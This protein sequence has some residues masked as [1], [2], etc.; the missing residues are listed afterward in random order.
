MAQMV[1]N[2]NSGFIKKLITINIDRMEQ[3]FE[4]LNLLYTILW[5]STNE[6]VLVNENTHSY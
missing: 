6:S 3:K 2:F 4:N 1:M 5:V